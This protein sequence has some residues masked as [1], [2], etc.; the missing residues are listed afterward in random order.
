MTDVE[1]ARPSG[2]LGPWRLSLSIVVST[3]FTGMP[4]PRQRPP[5]SVS[6]GAHPLVR[7]RVLRLVALSCINR[8][9]ADAAVAADRDAG[10]VDDDAPPAVPLG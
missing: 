5:G 1:V 7:R 4:W 6:T 8:V 2:P 3:V 10:R 9:L